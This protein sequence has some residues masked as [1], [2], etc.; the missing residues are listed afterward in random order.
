MSGPSLT[1]RVNELI[2]DVGLTE[3]RGALAHTLSGGQKRRLSLLLALIGQPTV[4]AL[5]EPT[6]GGDASTR[7]HI[8]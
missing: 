3:K 2:S 8:W 5:D 7:R 6:A 4:L 1:L